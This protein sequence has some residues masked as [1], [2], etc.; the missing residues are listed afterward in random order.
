M[1][2][3]I[4]E[5]W[6]EDAGQVV[7]LSEQL[8]YAMSLT[9]TQKQMEEIMGSKNDKAFVAIDRDK[10]VGWMHVF[11]TSRLESK[12][13]CEIGGLVVDENSRGK[14]VG[15]L[16]VGQA[17]LWCV[18]KGCEKL[19]VRSNVIRDKAHAFYLSCNF[20]EAK[21]QKVFEINIQK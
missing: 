4:R 18:A 2:I 11:Y 3:V 19:K 20:K 8:G 7:V 13:F 21:E 9:D 14:G 16:L 1:E 6:V 17:K 10:I 15:K 5:I 12:S